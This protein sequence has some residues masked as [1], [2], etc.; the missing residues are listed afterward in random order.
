ML[1]PTKISAAVLGYAPE[2]VLARFSSVIM[3]IIVAYG[4]LLFFLGHPPFFQRLGELA[5][6]MTLGYWGARATRYGIM[7]IVH[8]MEG[9]PLESAAAVAA[10]EGA[11]G[12]DSTPG[13]APSPRPL[14]GAASCGSRV[15]D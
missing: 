9:I 14:A 7:R 2:F 1:D 6:T 11:S 3:G 5:L 10:P 12:P 15:L 4:V 13:A 8:L